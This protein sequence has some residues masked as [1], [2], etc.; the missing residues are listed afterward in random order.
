MLNTIKDEEE[1]YQNLKNLSIIYIY[2]YICFA[3]HQMM[4]PSP[5]NYSST[6]PNRS[7]ATPLFTSLSRGGDSPS[8]F[9]SLSRGGE[10]PSRIIRNKNTNAVRPSSNDSSQFPR[11]NQLQQHLN[12]LTSPSIHLLQSPV[13]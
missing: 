9:T 8:L 1:L 11:N 4:L 6:G 3:G 10:S 5:V 7:P 13:R 12:G 2:V